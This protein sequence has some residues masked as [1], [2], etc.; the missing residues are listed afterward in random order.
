MAKKGIRGMFKGL[1]WISAC[2]YFL[3][4]A[5]TAVNSVLRYGFNYSFYGSE[6]I[7]TYLLV[8][9][10]FLIFP[11]LEM[12]DGHLKIDVFAKSRSVNPKI[13]KIVHIIRTIFA[14]GACGAMAYYGWQ[15][16]GTATRFQSVTPMLRI[17]KNI[18]FA[19]PAVCFLIAGLGLVYNLLFNKG[20]PFTDVS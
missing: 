2:F 9:V 1:F 13:K 8:F 20:G 4:T 12:Q 17:P 3:A 16:V 11:I 19:I 14:I 15:V 5:F 7:C 18:A 6:E 10:T